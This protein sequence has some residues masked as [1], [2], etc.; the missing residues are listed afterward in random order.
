MLRYQD[1]AH[2]RLADA[3]RWVKNFQPVEPIP[4][5]VFID[6]PYR[7]YETHRPRLCQLL[8]SLIEKLPVGSV[9]TLEAGRDHCREVLP[10][11]PTWDIR[12]YGDTQIAIRVLRDETPGPVTVT[13]VS[14]GEEPAAQRRYPADV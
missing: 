2:V 7:E 8:G 9:I 13:K 3:Y 14:V 6:P 1:R 12:R 11:F 5:A 10:D 4:M